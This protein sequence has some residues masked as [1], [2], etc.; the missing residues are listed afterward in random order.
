MKFFRVSGARLWGD[1]G[2][3]LIHGMSAHLSRKDGSIQLER[4]GP[5]VPS[6][7]MPGLGDVVITAEFKE[8]LEALPI[9]TGLDFKPV[10]KAR[11]VEYRWE[12]WDLN[13][14][15][16]VEY[17]EEG[18]PEDYI[19]SRPH[20]PEM[21][22]QLGDLW[23]VVLPEGA[24][25]EGVRIGR[26]VSEFRVDSSSW[27]GLPLFRAKGKRHVMATEDAKTWLEERAKEWLSFQE[28]IVV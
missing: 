16:P 12:S 1:Y 17:P 25:V 4:T 18:E 11:I 27:Q 15:E 9:S 8:E 26:G 21:A 7:T 10:S 6:I 28:A 24:E 13:R 20:S 2:K 3:I 19:L 14:E 23:E 22:R 5:F